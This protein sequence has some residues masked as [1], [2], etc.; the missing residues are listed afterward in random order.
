MQR[1]QHTLPQNSEKVPLRQ[2]LALGS[3]KQVTA[4]REGQLTP[5]ADLTKD[6]RVR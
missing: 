6:M 3:P 5:P 4:S 1:R 2:A